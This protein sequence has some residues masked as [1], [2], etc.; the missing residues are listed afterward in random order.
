M[1][2]LNYVD[3]IRKQ[4][5]IVCFK[6]PVDPDHLNT[7]GMGRKRNDPKLLEHLSCIP[8]CRRHHTE[9]HTKTLK[10]FEDKYKVNLWKECHD[11]L[12]HWLKISEK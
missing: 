4:K 3:Y 6:S 12:M 5:C 7:I 1:D 2:L 11:Y 10:D 9:R 8:L